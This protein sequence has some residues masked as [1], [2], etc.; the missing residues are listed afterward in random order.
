MRPAKTSLP[1]RLG[2]SLPHER[3][4]CEERVP[5]ELTR[6]VYATQQRAEDRR[7]TILVARPSNKNVFADVECPFLLFTLAEPRQIA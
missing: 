5:N 1:V 6:A 4:F 2:V 3:T 7:Y